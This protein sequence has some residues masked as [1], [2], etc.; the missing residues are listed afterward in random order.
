MG[1]CGVV[2]SPSSSELAL[3][4]A[5]SLR[6]GGALMLSSVSNSNA[7]GMNDLTVWISLPEGIWDINGPMGGIVWVLIYFFLL[8]SER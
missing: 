2:P 1:S 3:P 5:S 8:E 6:S 4:S 7:G